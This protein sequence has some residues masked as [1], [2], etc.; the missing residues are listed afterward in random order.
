VTDHS[1]I[2][3][4]IDEI[5][6]RLPVA[7][8]TGHHGDQRL[9]VSHGG[10]FVLDPAIPGSRSTPGQAEK[11]AAVTRDRLAD[12]LRWVPFVDWFLVTDDEPST[13]RLPCDLVE[14]TVTEGHSIDEPTI[15]RIRALLDFGV[16]TPPWHP[17][18]PGR[19]APG[20]LAAPSTPDGSVV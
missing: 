2:L 4:R 6:A 19:D 18:L 12:R 13:S 15:R 17:G 8:V 14:T 11:L 5:L 3:E 9:V 10:V 20:A 7:I 16:L 1:S